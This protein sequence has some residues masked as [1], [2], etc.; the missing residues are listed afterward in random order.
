VF[1]NT[2]AGFG[3][4]FTCT[5]SKTVSDWYYRVDTMGGQDELAIGITPGPFD[6]TSGATLWDNWSDSPST[7]PAGGFWYDGQQ[8][9]WSDLVYQYNTNVYRYCSNYMYLVP[10]DVIGVHLNRKTGSVWWDVNGL[11][12]WG[13]CPMNVNNVT[14]SLEYYGG[15][16]WFKNEGPFAFT[17]L[18]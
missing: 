17:Y 13:G 18:G 9:A 10:G 16:G 8:E 4:A 6:L 11:N 5:T 12:V 2:S 14:S 1:S 3:F 7:N 15:V